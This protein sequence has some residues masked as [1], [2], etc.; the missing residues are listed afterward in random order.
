MHLHLL[1]P[2][3]LRVLVRFAKCFGQ[4]TEA[5]DDEDYECDFHTSI[6]SRPEKRARRL[7]TEPTLLPILR[8]WLGIAVAGY[9]Q[10]MRGFIEVGF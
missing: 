7:S 1:I 10:E 5:E 4:K 8:H 3:Q 6:E 9:R 2:I